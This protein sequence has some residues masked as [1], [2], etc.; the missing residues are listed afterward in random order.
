[1]SP[2][3][4]VTPAKHVRQTR[5]MR[6]FA[7]VLGVLVVA[8][9]GLILFAVKPQARPSRTRT[10]LAVLPFQNLTGDLTE[11]YIGDGLT[12]ET[13]TR[14]GSLDP[15]RLGVI[16]RTSVQI[17]KTRAQPLDLIGRELSVQYVLEGSFRRNR[18]KLR[19]TAQLVRLRDRTYLWSREYDGDVTDLLALQD[20]I[21]QDAT[22]RIASVLGYEAPPVATPSASSP[23]LG[24]A[25]ELYLKGRFFWNQRT[26]EAFRRAAGLFEAAIAKAPN[27]AP[28]YA[29]LA[30]TYAL[31]SG[32]T[33]SPPS[34]LLPKARAAAERAVALDDKLAEAHTSLAVILQNY[35]WDFPAAEREYRRALA[36]NPNYA[37]AHHWYGEMLGFLGRFDEALAEFDRAVE[38]DPLSLIIANDRAVVLL[39]ARQYHRATEEFR[40]VLAVDPNFSR[41]SM[42]IY[43]Y[44]REGR[45]ADAIA[46]AEARRTI[47]NTL[48]DLALLTYA[49]GR[50]GRSQEAR[51][52]LAELE[53][54]SRRQPV[55]P[56]PSVVAY[57]GVGD[58]QRA[59]SAL[60]Q[61]VAVRSPS[62]TALKV[63]PLYDDLRSDQ[64][65][66]DLVDRVHLSR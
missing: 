62:V 54:R 21:A 57:L 33:F 13:I 14:L 49:Y 29:G 59:L 35:D 3:P 12:E 8:G 6:P 58:K 55:D 4:L 10:M 23:Q 16:S 46:Q 42:I 45:Y 7:L 24:E 41:A 34:E 5:V 27:Y 20:A 2:A 22:R 50:A 26:P 18:D 1:M 11:E 66:Q 52:S 28:A 47:N 43:A 64:R 40:K 53:K 38:L 65:F 56:A 30:D 17:Y 51:E 63:D 9:I 37:T 32:Y 19:I 39:F 15:Q 36:L 60:T 25:Y 61:A 44:V 31:M 48:W